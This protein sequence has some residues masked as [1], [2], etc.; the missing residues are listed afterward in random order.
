[1]L[2]GRSATAEEYLAGAPARLRPVVEH[3]RLVVDVALPGAALRLLR[4]TPT[5]GLGPT[6]RKGAVCRMSLHPASVEF[7]LL[8]GR[9]VLDPSGRLRPV[10]RGQAASVRI[11]AAA[12]VD[13]ALFGTWLAQAGAL[14]REALIAA[15]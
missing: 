4:G 3:L 15:P 6:A 2:P 5:W 13:S 8:R 9:L 1:M 7:T 10:G 12:E 14:E 11:G